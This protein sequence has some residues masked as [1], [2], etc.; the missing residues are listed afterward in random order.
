MEIRCPQ[1]D[2]VIKTGIENKVVKCPYCSTNLY[3]EK[4][5]VLTKESIKPT[6]EA[7]VAERLLFERTGK[8]LKVELEYFPFYRIQTDG[9]TIF[10]PGK[11]TDLIGINSYIPQGDRIT[12][13]IKVST[14]DL[15]I[16]EALEAMGE[17]E[18]AE[19]IGLIYLPFFSVK[20]IDIVYYV[21]GA[22]GNIL[23]NRL[24][25]K[26]ES[27]RNHH[28]FSLLSFSIIIM[29]ALFFPT[30]P[31]KLISVVAITFLLWYY[32]RGKQ[33]G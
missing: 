21:D 26:E 5:K 16:D 29:V 20:D 15:T 22:R 28:P 10:L 12:L 7:R 18:G 24:L 25:E 4:D 30:L 32:D 31:F 9:K 17:E 3:Y 23:S 13:D 2:A 27:A 33:N 11:K 8:K 19:S 1:C 14:P 6:L